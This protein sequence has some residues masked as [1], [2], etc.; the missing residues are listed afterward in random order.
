MFKPETPLWQNVYENIL[1]TPTFLKDLADNTV[2]INIR[3]FTKE[4]VDYFMDKHF[5]K[6]KQKYPDKQFKMYNTVEPDLK[7]YFDIVFLNANLGADLA[8]KDG[9]SGVKRKI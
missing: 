3:N 4:H 5:L 7:Q 9:N 8:I 1:A 2:S 6:L